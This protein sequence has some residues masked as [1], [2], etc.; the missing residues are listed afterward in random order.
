MQL[1]T[2]LASLVLASLTAVTTL[3]VVHGA[4]VVAKPEGKKP[5][6][7]VSGVQAKPDVEAGSKDTVSPALQPLGSTQL[8]KLDAT[9]KPVVNTGEVTPLVGNDSSVD[10]STVYK[11][12]QGNLVY[13]T[14][15]N[16]S[17]VTKYFQ[18][19]LSANG[20]TRTFYT[21][22]A[23]GGTAYPTWYGVT[24]TFYAYLY[25]WNGSAYA[26]DEY[27]YDTNTCSVSVTWTTSSSYPG[28]VLMTAK[29]NGTGYASLESNELAPYPVTGTYTG[30]HWDYP[31][32][33]GGTIYRYY[34][35]GTG[36]KFGIY[37]NLY[38]ALGYSPW[39]RYGT[40]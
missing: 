10:F 3:S 31:A 36:L 37:A 9:G 6:V 38:G 1:R 30:R 12:C 29:N 17:T 34:Y 32:A 22:V 23:A 39:Y 33:Y 25:V 13:T 18:V 11:Y 8:Q 26:Y 27:K 14:V 20:G 40:L 15:R 35:V 7:A 24:G 5:P 16:W 4:A 19:V 28:Y 21:S 2:K